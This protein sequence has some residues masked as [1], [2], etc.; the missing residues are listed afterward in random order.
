M[1]FFLFPF[2]FNVQWHLRCYGIELLLKF[3]EIIL[4][5]F[6]Q[7]MPLPFT[8]SQSTMQSQF[9][10]NNQ[11]ERNQDIL[12]KQV[13][14]FVWKKQKINKRTAFFFAFVCYNNSLRK[15]S[16]CKWKFKFCHCVSVN[17]FHFHFLSSSSLDTTKNPFFVKW[18]STISFYG[19]INVND[20]F[21][22]KLF[23]ARSNVFHDFGVWNAFK[24]QISFFFVKQRSFIDISY[25]NNIEIV[26]FELKND[27]L[28]TNLNQNFSYT[29]QWSCS[30]ADTW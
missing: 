29:V 4:S 22:W 6:V 11:K 19:K 3:Y 10:Y 13:K 9:E 15:A 25:V 2:N 26:W 27:A 23:I 5:S 14:V 16:F 8:V 30:L 1:T 21:V 24:Y 20:L 7:V 18:K 28:Q 17:G 12:E